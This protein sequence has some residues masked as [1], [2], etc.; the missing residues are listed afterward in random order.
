MSKSHWALSRYSRTN[1]RPILC[2]T[3]VRRAFSSC[4]TIAAIRF[5]KPVWSR[6]ENGMLS[7]SAHTRKSRVWALVPTATS[8]NDKPTNNLRQG[9]Y[10]KHSPFVRVMGKVLH[11]GSES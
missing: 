4:A 10:I 2:Q 11:R 7:G 8:S 9:E 3:K 1:P 5:S 6:L